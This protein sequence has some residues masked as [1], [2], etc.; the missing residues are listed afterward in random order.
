MTHVINAIAYT[1]AA[2]PVAGILIWI[3][4]DL[5]QPIG[6]VPNAEN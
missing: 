6:Q 4:V 5:V 3:L 1:F 2:L